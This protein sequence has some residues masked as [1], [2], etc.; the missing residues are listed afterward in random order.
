[1]VIVHHRRFRWCA[2]NGWIGRFR[3]PRFIGL[4]IRDTTFVPFDESGNEIRGEPIYIYPDELEAFRLVYLENM[5]QEDAAKMMN[6]SRGTLWRL[7]E[8]ARKKI[9][10]ALVEVR[11]I[12][13][14]GVSRADERCL[15]ERS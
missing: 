4:E 2:R 15:D 6:I 14:I 8:S 13:I 9:A 7:L 3:E 12:A 10:Q 1:M 11:P 5:S